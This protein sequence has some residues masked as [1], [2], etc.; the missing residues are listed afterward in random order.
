VALRRR[1]QDRFLSELG[2]LEPPQWQS[3]AGRR[4]EP[5]GQTGT[6]YR[7][8]AIV[9]DADLKAAAENL[10]AIENQGTGTVPGTVSRIG[11]R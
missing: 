11:V 7:R 4:D 8:Y 9:S 10:A 2:T 5:A 3:G 6:I 1:V